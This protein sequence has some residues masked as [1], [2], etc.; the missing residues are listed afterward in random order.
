MNREVVDG[1]ALCGADDPQVGR[2]S[3]QIEST[4][5]AAAPSDPEA[6]LVFALA[7]CGNARRLLSELGPAPRWDRLLG[8]AALENAVFALRDLLRDADARTVPTVVQRQLAYLVLEREHRV[9]VL[10]RRLQQ[11]LHVLN[12]AGIEPVLLKGAALATTVYGGFR[13]RPMNDIDLLVDAGRAQEARDLMLAIGWQP[14]A[15]MPEAK[16]RSHHHLAPLCDQA[17]AGLRLE[18]HR[19]LLPEGQPFR[20]TMDEL[21]ERAVPIR[22]GRG[23]ARVLSTTDH[24]IHIAIHFVW[25]HMMNVGAWHAFRDLGTLDRAGVLDWTALVDRAQSW[26]AASCCYWTLRLARALA[27]LRVP[28]PVLSELR[29]RLPE[30]VLQRV[31]RHF[32]QMVLR[33]DSACPSV[34]LQRA[35]WSLA[36]QP[37][38]EGHSAVRP[39]SVTVDLTGQDEGAGRRPFSERV[40]A[41]VARARRWSQYVGSML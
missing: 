27:Q 13:A 26:G 23:V 18:I 6:R 1:A 25:S 7:G 38:A 14:H 30:P 12:E 31:E 39:W 35:V 3:L 37:F 41:R 11:S 17:T 24:A 4:R 15:S 28:E 29:P 21:Y 40:R 32:S 16:Y 34:R 36:I 8:G 20:F 22:I 2:A 5:D 9:R 19:A 10:E 33:A